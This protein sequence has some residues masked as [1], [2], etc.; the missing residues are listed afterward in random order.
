MRVLFICSGNSSTGIGNV[1]SNQARSLEKAGLKIEF[2]PVTGKGWISYCRNIFRLIRYLKQ[3][4]YDLFHAHYAL[5]GIVAAVSLWYL[6]MKP[7]KLLIVSLMGSDVFKS[8]LLRVAERFF[9]RT[10]WAR[11]ITKSSSMKELLSFPEAVIIPNG[12][13]MNR[14]RPARKR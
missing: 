3:N 4:K 7:G 9:Y 13:D 11:V 6:G 12:V 5:S 8:R 10:L 1:V 14:Y 2:F